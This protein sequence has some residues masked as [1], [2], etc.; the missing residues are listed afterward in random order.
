MPKHDAEEV[1]SNKTFLFGPDL[2]AAIRKVLGGADL[3]CAVAFWGHGAEARIPKRALKHQA[4]LQ[5]GNQGAEPSD[6][7]EAT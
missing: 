1:L 3:R 7:P 2:E 5:P 6:H 4:D